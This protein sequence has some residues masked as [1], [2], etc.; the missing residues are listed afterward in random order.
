VAGTAVTGTIR[1]AAAG[2]YQVRFRLAGDSAS[3]Y[4]GGYSTAYPVRA[5]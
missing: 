1:F 3:R 5:T 2:T 4:V